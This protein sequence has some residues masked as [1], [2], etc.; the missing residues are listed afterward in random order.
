MKNKKIFYKIIA[1]FAIIFIFAACNND[2]NID[3]SGQLVTTNFIDD[4]SNDFDK[5][6]VI[7]DEE[8]ML[9]KKIDQPTSVENMAKAYQSLTAEGVK[10]KTINVKS[11]H[12]YVRFLPV[13]SIGYDTITSDNDLIL[14]N[15]PLDYE[16]TGGSYYKDPAAKS[17][18]GCYYAVVPVRYISPIKEFEIL[19]EIYQPFTFDNSGNVKF[20]VDEKEYI[21]LLTRSFELLGYED[22]QTA[23]T[24]NIKTFEIAV[25]DDVKNVYV[26][27]EGVRVVCQ[28]LFLNY[29]IPA[30]T[31]LQGKATFPFPSFPFFSKYFKFIVQWTGTD[32]DIQSNGFFLNSVATYTTP[33]TANSVSLEIDRGGM[34][35]V[36]AHVHRGCYDYWNNT[37]G[38]QQPYSSNEFISG[39][40]IKTGRKLPIV[41]LDLAGRDFT[42]I[43]T[44]KPDV[45]IYRYDTYNNEK[46]SASLY[47]T[48][49]HELAHVSHLRLIKKAGMLSYEEINSIDSKI[50]E[51]WA[52]GV[53]YRLS[54]IKYTDAEI[55]H[56]N[57]QQFTYQDFGFG[58]GE[59][60]YTP[61][62][63]DMMDTYDQ[64]EQGSNFPRDR[65]SGYTISQ[66]EPTLKNSLT[67]EQ[68]ENNIYLLYPN[69]TTRNQLHD[70]FYNWT[71]W[72]YGGPL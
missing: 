18:Y 33:Y 46:S 3:N 20:D 1:V 29:S 7:Q 12:L 67:W 70:L 64:R 69:N 23:S 10:F 19:N 9:L 71:G 30:V 38:L 24:E 8:I 49:I 32:W 61:V 40:F 52:V 72:A 43:N 42:T 28:S 60:K 35:S 39:F 21:T 27:L 62:V 4:K 68:W 63:I 17:E 45:K 5:I 15:F 56:G 6:K 50:S 31:N 16:T 2:I 25:Q 44:N 58:Y 47:L 53:A 37:V 34:Q 66:I 14:F 51:S 22:A 59:K 65:V 41:V 57:W 11:T 55:P 54:T 26:P 13:D 36:Y 48:V